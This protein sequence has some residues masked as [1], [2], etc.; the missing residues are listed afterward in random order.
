[1]VLVCLLPSGGPLL[2]THSWTS[3]THFFSAASAHFAASLMIPAR[4]GD[5][6]GSATVGFVS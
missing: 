4:Q 1:M 6:P 5:L 2:R 3:T